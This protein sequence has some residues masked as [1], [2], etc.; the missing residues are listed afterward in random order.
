M[1][2]LVR[3]INPT[4][5]LCICWYGPYI[6]QQVY[7]FVGTGHISYSKFIY[8]LLRAIY[9]TAS[10]YI[11]W[12]GPYILQQVYIFVGTGL[13]QGY[14][15][16]P[17]ISIFTSQ[18]ISDNKLGS[19]GAEAIHRML[20]ENRSLRRLEMSGIMCSCLRACVLVHII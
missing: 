14:I 7:I 19:Y 18:N 20:L 4:T 16:M 13:Q 10:L 6:L 12:Y 9:P 5:S 2:L 17:L 3:A 11:C 1:Y 15:L 8:L